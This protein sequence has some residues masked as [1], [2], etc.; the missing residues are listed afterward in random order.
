MQIYLLAIIEM[1]EPSWREE[2]SNLGF[3]N[4]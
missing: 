1:K 4:L 3:L 2:N